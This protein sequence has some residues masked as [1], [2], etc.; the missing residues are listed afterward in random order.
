M[1]NP[2]IVVVAR[3]LKRELADSAEAILEAGNSNPRNAFHTIRQSEVIY[4]LFR[5]LD[6]PRGHID[7]ILKRAPTPRDMVTFKVK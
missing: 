7:W 6:S 3:G 5:H 1:S 4:S 2:A